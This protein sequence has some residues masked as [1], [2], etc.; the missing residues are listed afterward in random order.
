MDD[1]LVDERQEHGPNVVFR[2]IEPN[3]HSVATGNRG[4]QSLAGF[5]GH[6]DQT[7][8]KW[9]LFSKGGVSDHT[10]C[11]SVFAI[12]IQSQAGIDAIAVPSNATVLITQSAVTGVRHER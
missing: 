9:I 1:S 8:V 11:F 5:V 7:P 2:R 12:D 6:V 10:R 3:G 4:Q